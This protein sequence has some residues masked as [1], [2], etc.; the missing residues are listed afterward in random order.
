MSVLSI[1]K[2]VS[3]AP[4]KVSVVAAL[5][6]GR[7]VADALT[8]LDHT[9]RRAATAVAKAIKSA[10]ANA[11]HN[12]NYKP[13]SLVISEISVTAGPRLKRYMPVARGMAH[14]FQK[15]SSHIRVSVD[16]EQRE[17]KPKKETK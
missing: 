2:G 1:A 16:G 7:T 6:R 14:P 9:P 5:V 15:K 3:I 11:E 4:R 13:A 12:H 10:A 17:I 8:I